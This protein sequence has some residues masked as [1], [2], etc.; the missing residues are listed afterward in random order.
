MLRE[1]YLGKLPHTTTAACALHG[2]KAPPNLIRRLAKRLHRA[3]Y[4]IRTDDIFGVNEA[5]YQLS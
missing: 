2:V 1:D 3:L 4:Q 5:L